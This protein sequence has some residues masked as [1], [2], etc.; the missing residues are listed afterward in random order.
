[1]MLKILKDDKEITQVKNGIINFKFFKTGKQKGRFRLKFKDING[2]QCLINNCFSCINYFEQKSTNLKEYPSYNFTYISEIE[3]IEDEF[4]KGLKV[5]FNPTSTHNTKFSFSISFK[6]YDNLNFTLLRLVNVQD[7]S[8]E[9]FKIHS[10]SPL[11]IKNEP[12]YLSKDEEPTNLE[13]ITWFK[14]GWQSWS[15]CKVFYGDQKDR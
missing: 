3:E 12:L 15:P 11:T 5:Q 8:S 1:M 9:Q 13:K 14:N 10:L 2:N 7:L 4:G 6:F